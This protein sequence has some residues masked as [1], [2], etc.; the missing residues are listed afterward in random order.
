MCNG[1]MRCF[2][3]PPIIDL[4]HSLGK[5]VQTKG[6]LFTCFIQLI[7]LPRE[8]PSLL[9]SLESHAMDVPEV[10]VLRKNIGNILLR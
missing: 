3:D 8:S 10:G 6:F 5:Q 7:D 1:F 4:P 9:N 2:S